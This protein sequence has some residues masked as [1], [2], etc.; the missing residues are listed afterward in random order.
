MGVNL[1][2]LMRYYV[3]G[4][5]R[6]FW[7]LVPPLLGFLICLHIWLSLRTPAKIVGFTWLVTGLLYGAYRTRW[8]TQ[9][10]E[11]ASPDEE[12]PAQSARPEPTTLNPQ[13]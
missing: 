8:F 11:F 13:P 7:N 3:R 6:T 2:A 9:P 5:Q 4:Q 10:V 1:S 12:P